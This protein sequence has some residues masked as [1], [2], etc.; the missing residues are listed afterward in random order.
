MYIENAGTWLYLKM[1]PEKQTLFFLD[2]IAMALNV[3]HFMRMHVCIYSD[4]MCVHVCL[5]QV[6]GFIISRSFTVAV[7][8]SMKSHWCSASR[9]SHDQSRVCSYTIFL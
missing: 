2:V 5:P 7:L 4:A 3:Y 1:F 9:H 6:T 8:I